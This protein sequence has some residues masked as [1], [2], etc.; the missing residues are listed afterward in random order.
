M[1][2]IEVDRGILYANP[3]PGDWAIHAYFP[4]VVELAPNELLCVYRRASALYGDDG[5]SYMMRSLD[6]GRT[7]TDE[8]CVHD[9][10]SDDRPY[11][12]SL[13][14]IASLGGD[15]LVL[16]G[17]RLARPRADMPVYNAETGGSIAR[18][19]ILCRSCDRGRT[20]S[21]PQPIELPAEPGAVLNAYGPVVPLESG[22]WLLAFD[23]AKR[24]DDPAPLRRHVVAYLSSDEGESWS[25]EVALAGSR[26]H[27]QAFFHARIAKMQDGRLM[28]FPWTGSRDTSEFYPL[29]RVVGSPDGRTWSEP[30]SAG[31]PGQTNCP[32]DLGQ[33]CLAMIVTVREAAEPGIYVTLSEDDGR[34]WDLDR[35]V[36]AWNAYGQDSLGV[37]RTDTYPASH[38]TI[39]F[40]A[41]DLI[42]LHDGDLLGSFW[43]SQRN[44]MVCRWTRLKLVRR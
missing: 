21:S 40:G 43:A 29:H 7:W 38:D 17:L 11:S 35:M 24:W 6:G 18:Q 32:A 20:W 30:E 31:V 4:R 42:R 5:R 26:R 19:S 2:L 36:Q 3:H 12:Y 15:R 14:S 44:Q 1:Q 25:E 37:P 39:A 8:G 27:G 33:G 41:P 13:T 28:A 16:S 34:T 10:S 23:P 22:Q 9:G